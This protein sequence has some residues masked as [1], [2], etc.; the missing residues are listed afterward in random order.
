M[1]ARARR[2]RRAEL[3]S[4]STGW[5]APSRPGRPVPSSSAIWPYP[6][7]SLEEAMGEAAVLLGLVLAPAVC[8]GHAR[9]R[10]GAGPPA[11]RQT[12]RAMEWWRERTLGRWAPCSGRH[13]SGRDLLL[14]ITGT[15]CFI[16]LWPESEA[17]MGWHAVEVCTSACSRV[18]QISTGIAGS[19]FAKVAFCGF[20]ARTCSWGL[21]ADDVSVCRLGSMAERS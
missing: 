8:N 12:H 5:Q 7:G 4:G 21:D 15:V 18:P 6:H 13:C 10:A 1:G 2:V 9:S 11:V 14:L 17:C 16:V 3:L 19:P 20:H